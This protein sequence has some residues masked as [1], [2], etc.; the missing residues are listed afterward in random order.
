LVSKELG[1]NPTVRHRNT[2]YHRDGVRPS[3]A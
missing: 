3:E 2:I 1:Y